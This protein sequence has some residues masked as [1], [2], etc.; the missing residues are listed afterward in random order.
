[1]MTEDLDD[2]S[3]PPYQHPPPLIQVNLIGALGPNPLFAMDTGKI[4]AKATG[5]NGTKDVI[6]MIDTG[7]ELNLISQDI[8]EKLNIPIDL[9]GQNWSLQ[10]INS[11]PEPLVGCCQNVPIEIGGIRFNHHFFV[12]KGSFEGH[13]MLLGQPWL[14]G[15]GANIKYGGTS[16]GNHG[17]DIQVY[18]KGNP[19]G[20][21]VSLHTLMNEE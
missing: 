15:V 18:E 16:E 7:S 4:V 2:E 17:M 13:N 14:V 8:Q 21:S 1:M 10:G 11:G 9:D 20:S 12:K 6:L 3:H 19:S 5:Q